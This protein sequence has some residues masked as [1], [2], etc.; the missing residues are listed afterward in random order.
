MDAPRPYRKAQRRIE[1]AGRVNLPVEPI[2]HRAHLSDLLALRPDDLIAQRDHRGIAEARR[3]AGFDRDRL[4]WN[5]RT[6]QLL[7]V[8]KALRA[9]S[10]QRCDKH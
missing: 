10:D 2:E 3:L 4:V 6:R 9:K 5:H 1:Q 8:R 7:I